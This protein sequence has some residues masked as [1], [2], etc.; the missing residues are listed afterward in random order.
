MAPAAYLLYVYELQL[1][2]KKSKQIVFVHFLLK[3][4]DL[5]SHSPNWQFWNYCFTV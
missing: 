3:V 2:R 4:V 1:R 5:F